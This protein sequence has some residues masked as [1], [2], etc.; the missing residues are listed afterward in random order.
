MKVN[1]AHSSQLTPRQSKENH[2]K[3]RL[4]AK[5]GDK[6]QEKKAKKV[7]SE[8]S[9]QNLQVKQEATVG[10]NDPSSVG[11][12]D[13]LRDLLKTGAFDFDQKE[14]RVLDKILN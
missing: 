8:I 7:D 2:I 1:M 10:K 13:K 5:F 12:Q 11:T 14:R 4:K 9:H 3:A 6:I